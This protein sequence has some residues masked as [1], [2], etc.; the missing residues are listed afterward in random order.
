MGVFT[1]P[2]IA[3]LL[4]RIGAKCGGKD[5]I[6]GIYPGCFILMFMA[7][8]VYVIYVTTLYCNSFNMREKLIDKE[9]E[10]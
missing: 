10:K 6:T 1:L 3:G 2:F 9:Y 7:Y 5:S 8:I 4:P